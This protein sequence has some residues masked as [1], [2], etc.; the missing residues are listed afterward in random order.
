MTRNLTS[1]V[2]AL[3]LLA[4]APAEPVSAASAPSG[5]ITWTVDHQ[6]KTITV[7]VH[8]EIYPG[9][10]G[11]PLGDPADRARA[12]AGP[13]SQ[14]TQFLAD[15]IKAQ[16]DA[17]WKGHTYRCYKLIINVDIKLGTD[18]SH[19]DKDRVGVRIDPSP[20]GIRD[21]VDEYTNN[22]TT[23]QSNDP[24]DRIVPRNDGH[25]ETT[26]SET[27]QG[28]VTTYPHELGHVLGL[29]DAYH[30]VP[31]P[32]NPG[33][34][35]SVPNEGAPLD[36]MSV[37]SGT[38]AQETIDR[39]VERNRN[40]LKDKSGKTVKL[41]DLRCDYILKI[42]MHV[43]G[44]SPAFLSTVDAEGT[45]ELNLKTP[46]V[47]K[48]PATY[49]G[50]GNLAYVTSPNSKK[51][52]TFSFKGSGG[53]PVGVRALIP[54]PPVPDG[55][56]VFLRPKLDALRPDTLI[57]RPCPV[58]G[59]QR[60]HV[61]VLTLF[62]SDRLGKEWKVAEWYPS[63]GFDKDLVADG[64]WTGHCTQSICNE[65]DTFTLLQAP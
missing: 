62:Y 51:P 60:K 32:D 4:G 49:E 19:L 23:W 64:L 25:W 8:L 33:H 43:V 53:F 21:F 50:L 46:A 42:K 24:A 58:G 16:I 17:V 55:I 65:R 36:L 40:E 5:S 38:I 3:V 48:T 57:V 18:R 11:D 61:V 14:V 1:I 41:S 6:A 7:D 29:S 47:G 34:T 45:I 26:W 9:C 63:T 44:V 22:T 37:A 31:D 30:D 52:C 10:S 39:L 27:S 12:C 15:K 35:K 59:L 28:Q 20:T 54:S 13:G 56:Q 2:L